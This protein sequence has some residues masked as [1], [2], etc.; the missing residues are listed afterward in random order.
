MPRRSH[1]FPG[2][3]GPLNHITFDNGYYYSFR[4]LDPVVPAPIDLS[5]AVMKTSVP[6]IPVSRTEQIPAV[7]KPSDQITV[8]IATSQAKSSEERIYLRWSTD[9]F[10]TSTLVEATG[11]GVSYSA[12]IPAQIAGA[13]LQYS[14]VTST[15]DL[16]P[17]HH[18]RRD[19]FA[20][21][22]DERNVQ[23]LRASPSLHHDSTCRPI[24]VGWPK[25]EVLRCGGRDEAIWVSV[26]E[27]RHK[28]LGSDQRFL[29]YATEHANRQWRCFRRNNQ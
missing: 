25:S 20:D 5:L 26:D 24:S 9:T 8:K 11:S 1:S 18:V 2:T 19:R 3:L 17:F 27:E 21:S 12:T 23:C 10:I 28:Y 6:P 13:L 16:D 22:R 15:A 7:P 14:I 29:R 4:I